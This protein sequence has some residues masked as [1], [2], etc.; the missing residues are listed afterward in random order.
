MSP[1]KYHTGYLSIFSH[2]SRALTYSREYFRNTREPYAI[3]VAGERIY[4]ITSPQDVSAT[5]KNTT[6]LTFDDYIR[7]MMYQFG[8]SDDAVQKM[9]QKPSKD[10]ERT[11]LLSPNPL[12]KN[13]AMLG[14]DLY[15]Q[16]LHPGA[17]FEDLQSQFMPNIHKTLSYEKMSN[18]IILASTSGDKTV[19]LLGWVREVLLDSAT[20]SFFGDRLLEIEPNLFQSFFDFDDNSWKLTYHL[21]RVFAREMYSAKQTATDALSKYFHLPEKERPGAAWLVRTLESEMRHLGIGE[22]DIASFLMMIYWVINGNAYKLCFWILAYVLHDERLLGVIRD[23]VAPVVKEGLP[24]LEN[25]LEQCPMLDSV[26]NEVLRLTASSSSVRTVLSTTN[27]GGK[28]LRSGTKVLVPYRQLHF[29]ED[30]WGKDAY[31]FN[32]ERFLRNKDLVR[33]SCFRP[34]G[35][36]T[37]YCPG[38]FLAKREVMTFIALVL[39]RFDISL[40]TNPAAPTNQKSAVKPIFPRLEE[41]KPCLGIMGP[42]KGDDVCL[43]VKPSKN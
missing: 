23:E 3:T 7:D 34:F 1:R 39:C 6:S 40:T 16:Q 26:Y 30:V 31:S 18:K 36:G 17:K 20:R 29:N 2:S 42:I 4:I 10:E 22:S 13:L 27:L 9:W 43:R 28:Q 21:P 19:S 8:G 32:P 14:E 25:R 33:N 35:G 24:G 5:Y 12:H 15:R 41:Q 38:R 11:K 37:T